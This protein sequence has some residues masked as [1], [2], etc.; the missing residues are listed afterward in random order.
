MLT[1]DFLSGIMEHILNFHKRT[2]VDVGYHSSNLHPADDEGRVGAS[3][4]DKTFTLQR[5]LEIAYKMDERPN[6][7]VKAGPN[8]KWYLKRFSQELIENA[9]QQQEWIDTSRCTMY[10]IEWDA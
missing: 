8:A 7:I 6:I 4:I 9:I 10:V 3:G 2:G 5:V 1:D